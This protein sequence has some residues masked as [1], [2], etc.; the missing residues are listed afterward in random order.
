MLYLMG[1]VTGVGLVTAWLGCRQEPYTMDPAGPMVTNLSTDA[2]CVIL[3]CGDPGH[4]RGRSLER[5][6]VARTQGATAIEEKNTDQLL[7]VSPGWYLILCE[8]RAKREP[9]R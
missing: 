6:S 4:N 8:A 9:P 1:S 5:A 2:A 3:I 7:A